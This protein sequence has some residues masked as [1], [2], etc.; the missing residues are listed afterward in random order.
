MTI[1]PVKKLRFFL[2]RII[3]KKI[4]NYSIKYFIPM[5]PNK[6]LELFY[7]EREEI[8]AGELTLCWHEMCSANVMTWRWNSP[9][10]CISAS[11]R[12]SSRL[13]NSSRLS[14]SRNWILLPGMARKCRT[15]DAAKSVR[16]N[17]NGRESR[18]FVRSTSIEQIHC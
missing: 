11:S 14:G 5:Y 16:I 10:D 12:W 17:K 8:R 18:K 3:R 7:K 13:R 9:C 6:I 4:N 1:S 2:N 15:K